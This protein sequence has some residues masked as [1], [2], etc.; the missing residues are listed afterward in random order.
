[1]GK[2]LET[3]FSDVSHRI[4]RKPVKRDKFSASQSSTSKNDDTNPKKRKIS[5]INDDD[6]HLPNKLQRLSTDILPES[7][8]IVQTEIQDEMK[9]N[10]IVVN[11]IYGEKCSTS[12]YVY[13]KIEDNSCDLFLDDELKNSH[14]NFIFKDLYFHIMDEICLEGLDGITIEAFWTR[15]LVV[16][17]GVSS[18]SGFMKENI[19]KIIMSKHEDLHFYELPDPRRELEIYDR[20]NFYNWDIGVV[21][22]L[23]FELPDI[24]PHS[25]VNV[26]NVQGSCANFNDRMDVSATVLGMHLK[27]IEKTY[28]N[29]LAIVAQQQLRT[30]A[31]SGEFPDPQIEMANI[32]Y[33]ILERIGR[34]RKLG[35]ITQG[36]MS[37]TSALKMDSKSVFHYRRQLYLNGHISKQFFYVKSALTDQNKSGKLLHLRRFFNFS[38]TRYMMVADKAIN[39]MKKQPG[40]M[41]EVGKLKRMIESTGS[42]VGK[43]FKTAEFRKYVKTDSFYPYRFV[44][45][46]A[47]KSEYLRKSTRTEK[48]LR[49]YE[50]KNPHINIIATWS[51][52]NDDSDEDEEEEEDKMIGSTFN[53]M[54]FLKELYYH[55][56]SKGAAGCSLFELN[57]MVGV[58][59]NS[60][61]MALKKLT[62]K[63]VI[64][65]E[66]VDIGR[67]RSMVYKAKSLQKSEQ[68]DSQPIESSSH[69]TSSITAKM[70][71][72][73]RAAILKNKQ[74]KAEVGDEKQISS[75]NQL[76]TRLPKMTPRLIKVQAPQI[77][78]CPF[79]I[80][81]FTRQLD[82]KH[83]ATQLNLTFPRDYINLTYKLFSTIGRFDINKIL[84]EIIPSNLKPA[85]FTN[86][87]DFYS[88]KMEYDPITK[89]ILLKA[90]FREITV[91]GTTALKSSARNLPCRIA[92]PK[93]KRSMTSS[94]VM[95]DHPVRVFHKQEN[96]VTTEIVESTAPSRA[97]ASEGG[98]PQ[99]DFISDRV[100]SR[101][102]LV[103]DEVHKRRVFEEP[104]KLLRIIQEE[105][106]NEGYEKKMD[107]KSLNRI[108]RRLVEEGYIKIYRINIFDSNIAK[109]LSF[110]CHPSI[111]HTEDQIQSACQQ[112]KWKYFIGSVK[113][114]VKLNVP[115][116][117]KKVEEKMKD[118]PFSES[119][120]MNSIEEMKRL[121]KLK[122]V[123]LRNR[124]AKNASVTHGVKPKFIR[125]RIVHE[126]LFYLV[127][128]QR[129]EG[130]GEEP[131]PKR[132]VEKL[133]KGYGIEI[134]QE[135][136]ENLPAVYCK[137]ISW[138]MF[139]PPLPHHKSWS[140]GW[141]LMCDVILRL[142]VSV[143]CK[144]HSCSFHLPELTETLRHPIKRFYLVK[145][146]SES[147]RSV[148]LFKRRYLFSIHDSITRLAYCGLVQYG[149]KKYK[150]KDQFFIY[151]N[152]KA[153]LFDTTSSRPSYNLIEDKMYPRMSFNFRSQ[154]DLENYWYNLYGICMNTKL[155][156]RKEGQVVVLTEISAKPEL[157]R[158]MKSRTCEEAIAND[159]GDIPGDKKG[160]ACLDS[161][162]WSHMKR[163]WFWASKV[164]SIDSASMGLKKER[165][166]KVLPKEVPFKNLVNKPSKIFLHKPPKD[167]PP[168]KKPKKMKPKPLKPSKTFN[169][170]TRK[171]P[172][173]K[174]TVR[175]QYYDSIDK[176]ILKKIGTNR[177][178]R[179]TAEEDKALVLCKIADLF[180]QNDKYKKQ[181]VPY[182]VVRDVL[183]RVCPVSKGKTSRA[184]QRRLKTLHKE[185]SISFSELYQNLL[186]VR[187]IFEYYSILVDKIWK[188][189]DG[190]ESMRFNETQITNVFVILM[191]YVLRHQDEVFAVLQG[192]V[193][194]IDHL[195]EN[196]LKYTEQVM[197]PQE[198]SS[199]KFKDATS[200]DEIKVD[201]LKSVIHSSV[202]CGNNATKALQLLRVYQ[203][204][205]DHLIRKA[206][207]ELRKSNTI[208]YNKFSSKRDKLWQGPYHLSQLY[209]FYQ[210]TTYNITTGVESY[211]T[212]LALRPNSESRS[213]LDFSEEGVSRKRYGQLLGMNEFFTFWNN[214]SF[215]F[216]LPQNMIILN[217]DM[218][219][220]DEL[221]AELARR[222]QAKMRKAQQH[223][224]GVEG[225][226][227]EA[228]VG[229]D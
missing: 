35:E 223:Q 228:D 112:M 29:K 114:T 155:N 52:E 71:E 26:P 8:D 93:S 109:S 107:K 60:C 185:S 219:N 25:V 202:V 84:K 213:S 149:P 49:C 159:N 227:G 123:E 106:K 2:V 21:M 124:Y 162:L 45:P 24:Y 65:A 20:L 10:E 173:R 144:V 153:S 82:L 73:Q 75:L 43:L 207:D 186:Q 139:I 131:V 44:Y 147:I 100:A 92:I 195:S 129:Q 74:I 154:T 145:D 184:V 210:F 116:V 194:D 122:V 128:E 218:A 140:E 197:V 142:P 105:E 32:Q 198:K 14:G 16:L 130:V 180:L 126:F 69:S 134:T 193:I 101:T 95:G 175:R 215:H 182:C 121:E 169:R 28:G 158:A 83:E 163:N 214:V 179:W 78:T 115:V 77:M 94:E 110:I 178:V 188:G 108:L 118:S 22:E 37:L 57:K 59:R 68:V 62:S 189:N 203:R 127:Y 208:T 177:R 190:Q 46:N 206:V 61:R 226:E 111:S 67:Q 125:M 63:G 200:E 135:E 174:T 99:M 9:G 205:P 165:M 72:R 152:R 120:V 97:Q 58:D 157:E 40:C 161:A 56:Y 113:K 1:M 211:R 156:A 103:I 27:D 117:I 33:C 13:L 47:K 66:K 146:L 172:E 15:L 209:I 98:P 42:L 143:L 50:L 48:M 166:N 222:Y 64:G 201:V 137:E 88:S 23:A 221:V 212:F 30:L 168:P 70:I 151:L 160:A 216:D 199:L 191:S 176:M 53:N 220:R 31:L 87:E 96:D 192:N 229:A 204:Y 5:G 85:T 119:D 41:M 132:E 138:K 133:F 34:S 91:K 51:H 89:I 17:E 164:P 183:H 80:P 181:I 81:N 90:M 18:I 224:E 55:I 150:E 7:L 171:I 217:P 4:L 102:R 39:I 38:K 11:K 196:N 76:E 225:E 86:F 12:D 19:W 170:L 167:V 3:K 6:S 79:L 141:A 104:H 54:E 136:L 187:P 148:T 36:N